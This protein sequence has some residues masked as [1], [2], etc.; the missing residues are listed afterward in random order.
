MSE[1]KSCSCCSAP[2]LIFACSGSADVG[3]LAD[4]AAR[5]LMKDGK[6][7]MFCLAGIGGRVSGIMKSTESASK[8]LVI[9]GCPLSCA[10]NCM[11]EAGFKDFEYINLSELGMQ[12]ASTE[13]SEKNIAVITEEASKK[14]SC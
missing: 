14:L 4:K 7:R 1:N 11:N 5:K 6:G 12:K 2:K 8:V 3:E 10:K 13:V 9:D